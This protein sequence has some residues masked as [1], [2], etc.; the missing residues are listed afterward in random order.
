VNRNIVG[1]ISKC[2]ATGYAL[3]MVQIS[4]ASSYSLVDGYEFLSDTRE[5]VYAKKYPIALDRYVFFHKNAK[6][7]D[8]N[9]GLAN[10]S[11]RFSVAVNDF[12]KLADLYPPAK[13]ALL[14]IRDQTIK[15]IEQ[16]NGKGYKAAYQCDIFADVV[17]INTGIKDNENTVI[18]FREL[19]MYQPNFAKRCF[20]FVK[21]VLLETKSYEL[22]VKYLPDPRKEFSNLMAEND[23]QMRR[24]VDRTLELI[25]TAIN[26]GWNDLAAEI[27][28]KALSVTDDKRIA[29]AI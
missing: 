5:Y 26:V 28:S 25:N 9:S 4:L 17:S 24:F 22:A 2:L 16:G 27:Q 1:K 14:E 20:P 11:I 12:V 19:D 13:T 7:K 6:K 23:H 15:K 18:V 3:F 29:N 8:G 10:S 21:S